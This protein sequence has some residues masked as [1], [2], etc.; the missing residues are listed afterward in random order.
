MQINT[1]MRPNR[2]GESAPVK[3]SWVGGGGEKKDFSV[4]V[5]SE[6]KVSFY[7]KFLELSRYVEVPVTGWCVN[8]RWDS[9]GSD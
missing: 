5:S 1:I 4:H 2:P 6:D 8:Q 7:S 3:I 9:A